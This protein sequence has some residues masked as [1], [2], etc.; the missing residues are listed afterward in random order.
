M[1]KL[2]LFSRLA[3]HHLDAVGDPGVPVVSMTSGDE[4]TK[5]RKVT[6]TKAEIADRF[7]PH[8]HHEYN[9]IKRVKK[10]LL[11]SLLHFAQEMQRVVYSHAYRSAQFDNEDCIF[12]LEPITHPYFVRTNSSGYRRAFSLHDLVNYI[13]STG[14]I[15]DPVDKEQ[16]TKS[17]FAA[18]DEQIQTL[19]LDLPF[20]SDVRTDSK[21]LE[22]KQQR[23][24]DEDI[25][26]YSEQLTYIF[27]GVV[28]D[29]TMCVDGLDFL[30]QSSY[31]SFNEFNRLATVLCGTSSE[32][33]VRVMNKF[34]VGITESSTVETDLFGSLTI[35]QAQ[36]KYIWT[37]ITNTLICVMDEV[38]RLQN[39]QQQPPPEDETMLQ[40]FA[41]VAQLIERHNVDYG[42]LSTF[43]TLEGVVGG[44][45]NMRPDNSMPCPAIRITFQQDDDGNIVGGNIVGGNF[46]RVTL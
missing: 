26:F 20:V 30:L 36:T 43:M 38:E 3:K 23:D 2:R 9:A 44:L 19:H 27:Q 46:P 11:V 21:Q 1:S 16:F 45:H 12:T 31:H 10:V 40:S 4:K 17:E 8:L 7:A 13:T 5:R 39:T 22:Y 35:D 34:S 41:L 29:I 24:L 18:I 6:M 25:D 37:F 14:A 28:Y 42:N 15:V 33:F 32:A